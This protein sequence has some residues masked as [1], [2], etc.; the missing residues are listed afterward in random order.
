VRLSDIQKL[1]MDLAMPEALWELPNIDEEGAAI[2]RMA[3]Y[4]GYSYA[5][6]EIAR[7]DFGGLCKR[8]VAGAT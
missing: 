2:L 5:Y 8:I 4:A 3:F 1:E 7:N 6:S